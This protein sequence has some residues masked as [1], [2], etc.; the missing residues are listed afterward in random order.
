MKQKM[1]THKREENAACKAKDMAVTNPRK[2][3]DI[4]EVN[5]N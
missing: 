1:Y 2:T 3:L 5:I 4:S